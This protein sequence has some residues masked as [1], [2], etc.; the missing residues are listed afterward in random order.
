MTKTPKT[1]AE[2]R[3]DWAVRGTTKWMD[4]QIAVY[5]R[6]VRDLTE[7]RARFVDAVET[8]TPTAT[9]VNVVSWFTNEMSN[10]PRNLRYDMAA[11]HAAA[12]AQTES[13]QS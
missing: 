3:R 13:V 8:P 6:A 12:L 9:P 1:E 7:M 4:E 2:Y 10:A 5:Q 11:V